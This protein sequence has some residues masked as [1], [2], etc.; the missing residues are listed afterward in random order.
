MASPMEGS[1]VWLD[2]FV[3]GRVLTQRVCVCALVSSWL[4]P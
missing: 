2:Q 3:F 1:V 4:L